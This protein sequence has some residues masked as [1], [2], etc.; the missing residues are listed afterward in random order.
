[1]QNQTVMPVWKKVRS[2][3]GNCYRDR[4]RRD[5][6]ILAFHHIRPLDGTS[7]ETLTEILDYVATEYRVLTLGELAGMLRRKTRIPKNGIVLTFDDATLD[8]YALAGPELNQ[9]GLRATFAI[10]GCTL[11]GRSVPPLH[12]YLYLLEKTIKSSVRFAFPPYVAEQT[13]QLDAAGKGA[14]KNRR[15]PLRTAIQ[16]SEHSLGAEIVTALGETLDVA[17]PAVDELF[18]SYAQMRELQELGHEAAAHSMRHQDVDEPDEESW[19]RDL[20]DCFSLMSEAFGPRAHPYIYPFGRERRPK[21]HEKIKQ[22]G[23]CC[24]ATTE[25]GTN[26]QGADRFA[27]R[28]IGIDSH[29]PVPL[30]T[31]Y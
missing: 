6:P 21:I 13:L 5:V 19:T 11:L 1:M 30:A 4:I 2:C 14:L 25:P 18:V 12:W 26:R 23:F 27:L 28:R 17:P 15:S 10:I 16:A 3:L 29:T 20:H 8:Q 24:A 9:R 7:L 31:I 22:A